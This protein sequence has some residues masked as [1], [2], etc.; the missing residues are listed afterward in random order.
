MP[1]ANI[2]SS[3]LDPASSV[4]SKSW[5]EVVEELEQALQDADATVRI[6]A[7]EWLRTEVVERDPRTVW[8]VRH[9]F[10]CNTDASET[11]SLS[12]PSKDTLMDLAL[13]LTRIQLWEWVA[14]AARD[15]LAAVRGAALEVFP[16]FD[17]VG[18]ALET[19]LKAASDQ[20]AGVREKA[21]RLL[22]RFVPSNARCLVPVL[23][24]AISDELPSVRQ[25]ALEALRE[26]DRDWASEAVP[27]V[28]KAMSDQ[29]SVVRREAWLTLE[30][31]GPAEARAAVPAALD[32][33]LREQDVGVRKTA[34]CA[35]LVLDPGHEITF[36]RLLQL[37]GEAARATIARV[38]REIGPEAR[39][40]RQELQAGWAKQ[41]EPPPQHPDGPEPDDT[42]SPSAT[43]P[44]VRQQEGA[45][46]TAQG[47]SLEG[48]VLTN[49]ELVR[50]YLD[51][52]PSPKLTEATER[53]ALTKQKIRRTQ[54]WKDYEETALD[55]YLQTHPDAGTGEVGEALECS[56]S[57][58][59]H[60]RAW[61]EHM[62]RKED[63]RQ[64]KERPLTDRTARCRPDEHALD[65]CEQVDDGD[66]LF[67]AIVQTAD[68]D[69]RGR[70]NRLSLTDQNLLIDHIRS[71]I[72]DDALNGE[73]RKHNLEI[74]VEV[75]QS[76]LE[77]HEQER[78][79]GNRK[80]R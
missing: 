38:L 68:P 13:S 20:D 47:E 8:Q 49:E 72:G 1:P 21:I 75:A 17:C 67:H 41:D 2:H 62:R 28:I 33:M 52:H 66:E 45:G 5:A 30:W 57:K 46:A 27:A 53:T 14:A 24:A 29:E 23:V 70:L 34:V 37:Q 16:F 71:T 12:R 63:A 56:P 59:V 43:V 35:L 11:S 79:R 69:T 61:K 58:V 78:R 76:W 10:D 73:G 39:S 54:A 74:A 22:K 32:C 50:Q 18:D 25:A 7:L 80:G 42:L 48:Q 65:P 4:Q 44:Q 60:M 64:I 55:Q 9:T 77:D 6:R 15:E 31:L 3:F 19:V 51:A 36:P 26:C 40:L